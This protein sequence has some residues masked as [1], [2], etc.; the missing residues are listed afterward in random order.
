M[1][2]VHLPQ[3]R[4]PQST[5]FDR[6]TPPFLSI[7]NYDFI[8][9]LDFVLQSDQEIT[10]DV[11]TATAEVG[12]ARNTEIQTERAMPEVER[13]ADRDKATIDASLRYYKKMT[14]L[15]LLQ[16]VE[17]RLR[18]YRPTTTVLLGD[19]SKV[20]TVFLIFLSGEGLSPTWEPRGVVKLRR[21]NFRTLLPTTAKAKLLHWALSLGSRLKTKERL[22]HGA[23][24]IQRLQW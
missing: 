9:Q 23:L 24:Q 7:N 11:V 2:V 5:V 14:M 20:T 10:L 19:Y 1:Y 16:H 17:G 8:R 12:A 18:H 15:K 21:H 4:L 13:D 22:Q 6:A 3:A